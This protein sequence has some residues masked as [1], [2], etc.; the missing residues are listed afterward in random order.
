[1]F[2]F[3]PRP[4]FTQKVSFHVPGVAEKQEFTGHF[5]ALP[6]S[7]TDELQGP[8][9]PQDKIGEFNRRW[10]ER[11]FIG[12]EGIVDDAGE[13]IL[14]SA[15]TRDVLLDAPWLRGAVTVAYLTGISGAARKN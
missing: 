13:L 10:L 9:V 14:F 3:N 12:W 5:Q 15:E 1:M 2:K 4:T 11:I 7:E 8:N 6:Q